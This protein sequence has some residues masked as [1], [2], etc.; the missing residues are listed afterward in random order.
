[1]ENKRNLVKKK[2]LVAALISRIDTKTYGQQPLQPLYEFISA[3]LFQSVY[4]QK[5]S[6]P[7][8]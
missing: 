2:N 1:M 3:V 5:V 4:I 6:P 8:N 7:D